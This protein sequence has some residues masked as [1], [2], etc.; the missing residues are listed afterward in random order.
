M[1]DRMPVIP[2]I[3]LVALGATGAWALL[4]LIARQYRRA[5][6]E[7]E[8]LRARKASEAVKVQT[9]RRDPRTGIYR[10]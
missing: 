2:P 3:L 4:R 5:N 9:L 7:L 10:P 6:D 1:E 8:A